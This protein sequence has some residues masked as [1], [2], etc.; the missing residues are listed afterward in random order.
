MMEGKTHNSNQTNLQ[1]VQVLSVFIAGNFV[2]E[3]FM[4][5]SKKA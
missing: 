3:R 1:E 5:L 4:D 2:K